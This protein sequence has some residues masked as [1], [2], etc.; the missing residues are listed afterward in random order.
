LPNLPGHF[1]IS[2]V[3][4]LIDGCWQSAFPVTLV[5]LGVIGFSGPDFVLRGG[6]VVVATFARQ[7]RDGA[8]AARDRELLHV[9]SSLDRRRDCPLVEFD[10][11]RSKGCA[12]RLLSV[13][14]QQRA[15]N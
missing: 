10:A 12:S 15:V 9:D 3:V 11:D 7:Q 8:K 4:A 1:Q 14:R 5:A 13:T 6:Y 2:F